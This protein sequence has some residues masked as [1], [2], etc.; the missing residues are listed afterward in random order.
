LTTAVW[1]GKAV[2]VNKWHGVTM[3]KKVVN[4][5]I[6]RI[7]IIYKKTEYRQFMNSMAIAFKKQMK[8]VAGKVKVDIVMVLNKDMDTDNP[9][10]PIFDALEQAGILTNDRMQSA[11]TWERFD[12]KPGANDIIV[13]TVSP[14][15]RKNDTY[16]EQEDA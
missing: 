11:G 9:F 6:K 4:G 5:R 1:E 10:K 15:E 2:S 14:L 13:V 16:G 8:P 12:A 7:P 3:Q